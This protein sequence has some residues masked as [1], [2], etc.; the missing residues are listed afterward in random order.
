MKY[1]VN[2]SLHLNQLILLFLTS[3]LP[4]LSEFIILGIVRASQ[5]KKK[6][7]EKD[8]ISE[9]RLTWRGNHESPDILYRYA[10]YRDKTELLFSV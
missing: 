6:K 9:I 5:E 1:R 2:A 10:S 8:S 4:I 3:F 7:V